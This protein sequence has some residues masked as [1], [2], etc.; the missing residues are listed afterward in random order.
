M[1]IKKNRRVKLITKCAAFAFIFA[2]LAHINVVWAHTSLVKS[3]PPRRATL[4][5]P[6]ANIQLWFS[7][8]IEVAYAAVKVLD[9]DDKTVSV[10]EPEAVEDDPKSIILALPTL[11]PG[12]YDVQ[13]RVLSLDGHVVESSYGFR[14][15]K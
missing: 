3:D 4:S 8:E 6:P 11:N 12:R 9:G 2:F 14:I 5:E 1:Q 13:Y 10:G 15:K 7:E